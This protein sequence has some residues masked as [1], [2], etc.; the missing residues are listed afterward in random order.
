MTEITAIPAFSDN[1]IWALSD[2]SDDVVVVGKFN[3][4]KPAS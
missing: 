3:R 4:S 2:G 1:Y